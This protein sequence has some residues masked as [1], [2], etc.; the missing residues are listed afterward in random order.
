MNT[1]NVGAVNATRVSI[2][3]KDEPPT[4]LKLF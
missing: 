3:P 1:E 4:L 2:V